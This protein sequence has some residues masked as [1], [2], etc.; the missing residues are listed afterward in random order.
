MSAQYCFNCWELLKL[1]EL[2][3]K[4]ETNLSVKGGE[5][6]K[7]LLDGI[8]LKPKYCKMD[9]QQLSSE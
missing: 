9:N 5:S 2:Q 7:N 1:V 3:R 4:D 6:K 8:W